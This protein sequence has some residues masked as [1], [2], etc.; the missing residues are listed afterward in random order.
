MTRNPMSCTRVNKNRIY[1]QIFTPRARGFHAPQPTTTRE[2]RRVVELE[3]W[4]GCDGEYGTRA[5]ARAA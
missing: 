1:H 3:G 2:A 5:D 4:I